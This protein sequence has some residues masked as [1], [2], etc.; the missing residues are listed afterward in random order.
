[1][2][3]TSAARQGGHDR[4]SANAGSRLRNRAALMALAAALVLPACSDGGGG[5]G[6]GPGP[7]TREPSAIQRVSPADV[8]GAPGHPV[9]DTVAVRVVDASGAPMSGV[10]VR[11]EATT[12][13][14]SFSPSTS[15]TDA[16][17]LAKGVWTLGAAEGAQAA[18]ASVPGRSLSTGF[19]ATA[20]WGSEA[21]LA[22]VSGDAQGMPVGCA[23]GSPLEVRVTDA[24]SAPVPGAKVYFTVTEGTGKLERAVAT[25]DAQGIARVGLTMGTTGGT[26]RI[27][28]SL[29]SRAPASVALTATAVDAAA[30][31]YAAVGPQIV[32]A[33]TCRP[34]RFT[35]IARSGLE[36]WH[37]GDDRLIDP[38]LAREDFRNI[39]S[40]GANVVR[41]PLNPSFWLSTA[42]G[43][44]PNYR[45]LVDSTVKRAKE[46]GLD[47][48]LD[49]H[50]SDRGNPEQK[51]YALERMADA[52]HA[53]PFWREVAAR[54]KDDGRVMFELYNE[55]HD[56]SWSTWRNGGP[57]GDGYMTAGYQQLYDAVRGTGARNLVIVNGLNWGFDLGEAEH[58]MIDGYNVIY[59]SHV[60]DWPE[61]QP[62][63]WDAAFG[64]LT[65]RVP[66]MIGE[67][68]TMNCG[69]PYYQ[70]VMDYADQKN[71][72]WVAWAWYAP[73]ADRQDLKC[74]FAA[75]ISS[76]DGTPTEM[77]AAVRAKL[78]S[79]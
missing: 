15:T 46:N 4:F 37:R 76:W 2:W 44:D 17:G 78:M 16:Q 40:W 43:Y 42:G 22:V 79:Y 20:R 70:A 74:T 53:I 1:M 66:V 35:G 69:V 55:P 10:S 63:A 14:G 38:Q 59:G 6:P 67:F 23:L 39:R 60:Y 45:A 49:M 33:T 11:F 62:P 25:A 29:R 54:Y 72:H 64:Y 9:D 8:S 52:Q 50:F 7:G 32:S 27:Q 12:G 3:H 26:Q 61:K 21:N 5:G 71:I 30:G 57:S 77:G 18:T 34:H 19:T 41:I 36:S 24:L 65:A 58:H 48:I 31:G 68:G 73:P 56:I 13:G 51:S 28:A 75:L 47:V